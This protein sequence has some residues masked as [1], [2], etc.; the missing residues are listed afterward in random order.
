[1]RH[2]K[3]QSMVNICWEILKGANT[4]NGSFRRKGGGCERYRKRTCGRESSVGIGL[5][6][7]ASWSVSRTSQG[8]A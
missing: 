8:S 3:A 6:P 7:E 5:E 4:M 1:M 2:R